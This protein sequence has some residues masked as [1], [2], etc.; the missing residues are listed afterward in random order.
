MDKLLYSSHLDQVYVL[1]N[2]ISLMQH[3]NALPDDL[4][5]ATQTSTSALRWLEA[6]DGE[7]LSKLKV[8]PMFS[9]FFALGVSCVCAVCA[10]RWRADILV[11]VVV[12]LRS[13][14]VS[15]GASCEVRHLKPSR[16]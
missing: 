5:R 10:C 3:D 12:Y 2:G 14:T 8:C 13:P 15:V 16:M 9:V 1:P 6:L 4:Q 11:W 7:R